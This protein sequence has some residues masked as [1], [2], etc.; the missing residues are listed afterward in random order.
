MVFLSDI[1]RQADN[2][3]GKTKRKRAARVP[4][5]GRSPAA[6]RGAQAPGD[7]ERAAPTRTVDISSWSL[8]RTNNL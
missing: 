4:A 2:G 1:K 5:L 3:D 8:G 7:V 6:V